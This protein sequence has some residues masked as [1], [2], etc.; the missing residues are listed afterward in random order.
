MPRRSRS[1]AA[2]DLD[3][4]KPP[5]SLIERAYQLAGSGKFAD[6]D[7]IY[8]RLRSDGYREL[9]REFEGAA[10]RAELSRVCRKAQGVRK[11]KGNPPRHNPASQA[12]RAQR[13]EVKAAV[14]R[15]IA[16]NAQSAE[17][18]QMYLQL[19]VSYEEAAAGESEKERSPPPQTARS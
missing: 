11:P 13:F 8:R 17:T 18:R 12:Q 10:L 14:C 7:E 4:G 9:Y 3:P 2:L 1:F 5:P 15:R 19:A 16:D 6:L